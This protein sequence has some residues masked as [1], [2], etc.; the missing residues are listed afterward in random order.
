MANAKRFQS[1]SM[2]LYWDSHCCVLAFGV[3]VAASFQIIAAW[4]LPQAD[5]PNPKQFP[6]VV[7]GNKPGP[8]G[9]QLGVYCSCSKFI[10]ALS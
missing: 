3:T 10:S 6:F 9:W 8:H 7:L 1:P 2:A 4:L 5:P